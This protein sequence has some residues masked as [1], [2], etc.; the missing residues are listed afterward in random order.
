MLNFNLPQRLSGARTD[1]NVLMALATGL[2]LSL[3]VVAALLLL[4]TQQ[5]AHAAPGCGS[6]TPTPITA[7]FSTGGAG[8]FCWQTKDLGAYIQSWGTTQLL[9]NGVDYTNIYVVTDTMLRDSTGTFYVY[10]N[11]TANGHF[12][13]TGS[14]GVTNCNAAWCSAS[15]YGQIQMGEFW[16]FNNVWGATSGSQQVSAQSPSNFWA[17]ATFPETSGVK[18]YPNASLDMNGKTISNLGSCT[19]S[20]NITPPSSGSWEFAYDIWVPSEIMIWVNK[21]G[22]V[23]P[24]AED[25]NDDGT[26]VVTRADVTVGG[27]TWDV[28]RGGANVISFLR[29]GGNITSGSVDI[30]AMLNWTASQGWISNTANLGKFQFGPEITSAPGGLR[31]TTNSYSISCGGRGGGGGPTPTPTRTSAVTNT[32]TRTNT[33]STVVPTNTPTRTNTP[34]TVVPTNTST[35]TPTRTATGPT[36]TRTN[37]RTPTRTPTVGGSTNT[38]TRTNTPATVVPTNTPTRTPTS[39][40][41]TPC[42]PVT[43]TITA[44]FA[45]DG[46]GTF[47]WQSNNLGAFVNSWNTTSVTL[48]GVNIT[49]V[50]V[51]ASSYPPQQGGYWYVGYSSSVAWGHFEAK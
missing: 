36:P 42:S 16:M 12:E 19:S 35:R 32:P 49:N 2:G 43:S 15:Q 37:T 50:Y 17:D 14:S 9:V 1:K 23:G 13:A 38:P 11:A 4:P 6:L 41:G 24:I 26:P 39:G 10:Y 21:N 3:I 31:F 5:V 8:E 44:P 34:S 33:P 18:S 30:L 45:F 25:W 47:C 51:A 27:H 40:G 20:F 7:P 22:L 29:K 48:N 28:Y 46:A